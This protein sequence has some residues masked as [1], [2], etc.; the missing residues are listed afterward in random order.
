[1]LH[2]IDENRKTRER[3]LDSLLQNKKSES[4]E[5]DID[6]FYKSIAMSV[7]RLPKH[8]ISLAKTQHLQTLVNLETKAINEQQGL[9]LIQQK[10]FVSSQN[11]EVAL[12]PNQ[13]FALSQ[14]PYPSNPNQTRFVPNQQQ[15]FPSDDNEGVFEGF[16]ER[17]NL[18]YHSNNFQT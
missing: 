18:Q 17:N 1:M 11:P 4:T 7:K 9:S 6:L 10:R 8:L 15:G 3:I 12:N 16:A 13:G 5:D 2:L 14:P